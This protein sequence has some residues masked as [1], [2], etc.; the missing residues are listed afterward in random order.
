MMKSQSLVLL[1]WNL[2]RLESGV[3][4]VARVHSEPLKL[5]KVHVNLLYLATA[6]HMEMFHIHRQH[7]PSIC[8]VSCYLFLCV[9]NTP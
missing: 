2:K 3:A 5:F 6:I 9:L 4:D 7:V 8:Q 1:N